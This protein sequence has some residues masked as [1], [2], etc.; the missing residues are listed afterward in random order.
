MVERKARSQFPRKTDLPTQSAKYWAKEK[1]RYLRQLLIADI[2]EETNRELVVYF[3]RL[4]QEITETDADDS[5][6]T[7]DGS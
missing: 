2:E 3:C 5:A 1:D 7:F 4:D 6:E